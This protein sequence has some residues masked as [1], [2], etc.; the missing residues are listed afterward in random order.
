MAG[1]KEISPDAS[2]AEISETELDIIFTLKKEAGGFTALQLATGHRQAANVTSGSLES[3]KPDI[4][5]VKL[6]FKKNVFFQLE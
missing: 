6:A 3:A 1:A 2:V 5:D 4:K